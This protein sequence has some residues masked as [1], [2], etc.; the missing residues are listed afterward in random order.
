MVRIARNTVLDRGGE[1]AFP[2]CSRCLDHVRV[3]R[4]R[5]TGFWLSHSTAGFVVLI[6]WLTGLVSDSLW[7][8]FLYGN[9]CALVLGLLL[10]NARRKQA[11][12]GCVE[13]CRC[14]GVSVTYLGWNGSVQVFDI[15]SEDYATDFMR[16]NEQKLINVSSDTRAALQRRGK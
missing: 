7:S 9:A 14:P 10:W 3:W 8:L 5:F 16:S 2:Y 13:R 15:V 11:L 4:S 12:R 6:G 1:L